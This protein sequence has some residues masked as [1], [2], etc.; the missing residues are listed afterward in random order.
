MRSWVLALLVLA[1][2]TLNAAVAPPPLPER[3]FRLESKLL[4]LLSQ[5]RKYK[6]KVED[7]D[8]RIIDIANVCEGRLTTE[9]GVP[10]STTNM[11]NRS[12]LYFTPYMGN[13]CSVY[14]GTTWTMV[15]FVEQS[16]ALSGLTAGRNYDIFVYSNAG[17]LTIDTPVAWTNDFT[18]ATA[19][20][21]QDGVYVRSG[22]TTRRYVGTI[23]ATSATQTQDTLTQRFVWNYQNRLAKRMEVLEGT[24]TWTYLT[25]GWRSANALTT[26]RIQFVI[27]LDEVLV[28]AR[29]LALITNATG[30]LN[31]FSAGVG[32]DTTTNVSSQLR[33]AGSDNNIV[34]QVWGDYK[35]Y[36]PEGFHYLQWV[37]RSA[38]TTITVWGDNNAPT[39]Y[40]S[41]LLGELSG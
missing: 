8:Q 22:A 9:S 19:L 27:G 6:Q 15:Q 13:L 3:M 4:G 1:P 18:R 2:A 5:Y 25:N 37:E 38:G 12:T 33:G 23:R 35:G 28:E 39:S 32:L 26:N 7:D 24:N 10:L 34:N 16:L 40:Q 36:P 20:A 11:A 41:G 21:L 30:T 31:Y 17:T 14:N 29:V